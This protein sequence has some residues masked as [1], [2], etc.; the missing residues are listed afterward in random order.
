MVGCTYLD[1]KYDF[2]STSDGGF[3]ERATKL[4]LKILCV[5]DILH[6]YIDKSHKTEW[7][8]IMYLFLQMPFTS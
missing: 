4:R 7:K 5:N 8:Y 2:V 1:R 3:A 6:R